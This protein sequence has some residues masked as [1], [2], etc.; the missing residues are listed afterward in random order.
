MTPE[1]YRELRDDIVAH[2]VHEPLTIW[3]GKVIDGRH[4]LRACIELG[5]EPPTRQYD[6]DDPAGFVLSQNL[7]RRHL[8]PSQRA[9]VAARLATLSPGR[10]KKA[11]TRAGFSQSQAAQAVGVSERAIREAVALI[12]TAP[13]EVLRGVVEGLVSLKE[14]QR[15]IKAKSAELRGIEE[16]ERHAARVAKLNG[17]TLHAQPLPQASAFRVL[18]VDPPWLFEQR[19]HGKRDPREKYPPMTQDQLKALPVIKAAAPDALLFL[20]AP[21]AKLAEAVELMAAWDF[22]YRTCAVWVKPRLSTG[23]WMRQR[24]ELLL[25][26]VRGSIPVPPPARRPVSV[27]EAPTGRHSEK[28]AEAY[29]L[30]EQITGKLSPKL[31]LFARKGVPGWHAWGYEAPK[32]GN[33][34]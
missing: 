27:I 24:A 2:G 8:K 32:G 23:K 9:I 7:H 22:T 30:I 11:G 18:L 31:E 6:G 13:P 5:I 16:V 29:R 17:L 25:L 21:A 10:P 20:W 26:G 19:G 1:E 28:P 15:L 34:R 14:G 12:K 33:G 3:Q 4:R